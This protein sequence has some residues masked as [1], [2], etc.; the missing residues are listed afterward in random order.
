M[1]WRKVP[2]SSTRRQEPPTFTESH[3]ERLIG[4]WTFQFETRVKILSKKRKKRKRKIEKRSGRLEETVKETPT[5]SE[6]S[7]LDDTNGKCAVKIK[8]NWKERER[9][10]ERE[11]S[12]GC[13]MRR[14]IS[15]GRRRSCN[16]AFHWS[17]C[18]SDRIRGHSQVRHQKRWLSLLIDHLLHLLLHRRLGPSFDV[19]FNPFSSLFSSRHAA[20]GRGLRSRG[21][22]GGRPGLTI[23]GHFLSILLLEEALSFEKRKGRQNNNIPSSYLK[24]NFFFR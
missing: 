19:P 16:A 9:E 21:G 5:F 20:H 4:G 22:A 6:P 18:S 23:S 2:P 3:G 7:A 1:S 15:S 24:L 17:S 11:K 13:G 12:G 14:R 8:K 10:R